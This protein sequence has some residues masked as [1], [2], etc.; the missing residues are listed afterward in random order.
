MMKRKTDLCAIWAA[1]GLLFFL[2]AAAGAAHAQ[3]QTALRPE[4]AQAS[5]L[6]AGLGA[7]AITIL[8]QPGQPLERREAVFRAILAQNFNLDFIG[9][10]AVGRYWQAM[11]AE[12]R[13]EY[14]ALFSEFVLRTYA[15]ML[16]GYVDEKFTVQNVTEAGQRDTIISS[17]ITGAK[18]EPIHADWRVRLFDGRPQIIDVS[19]G[20]ISMSITQRE[21]FSSVV[22]RDGVEGLLEVL[23]AR[24]LGLPAEGPR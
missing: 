24:T 10:F 21:Q 5:Q 11:S 13:D 4:A 17:L 14:Q 19:V 20:G 9:R 2:A 7:Q 6:I 22:Q 15:S 18:R 1:I 12:Q 3:S 8:R 23:R 16:G